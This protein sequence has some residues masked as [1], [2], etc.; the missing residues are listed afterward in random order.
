MYP[1]SNYKTRDE[2]LG[3]SIL[4]AKL[5]GGGMVV[6]HHNIDENRQHV[7]QGRNCWCTPEVHFVDGYKHGNQENN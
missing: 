3:W 4:E 1:L 5:A 2:A 6:L 7:T